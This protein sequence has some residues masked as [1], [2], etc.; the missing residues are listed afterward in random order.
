MLFRGYF[1]SLN[2]RFR[3]KA[4][5]MK[6]RVIIFVLTL[7]GCANDQINMTYPPGVEETWVE[8]NTKTDTLTFGSLGGESPI[9]NLRRGRE[10]RNGH[11]LPKAHSG[12]YEYTLLPDDRISIRW[13]LSSNSAYNEY[14][15]KRSGRML[16]IGNFY[17]SPSGAIVTFERLN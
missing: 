3:S 4:F 7:S 15:F 10:L 9:M 13:M 17:E 14:Y 8:V 1:A 12:L 2:E 11:V 16:T 6:Y 5:T